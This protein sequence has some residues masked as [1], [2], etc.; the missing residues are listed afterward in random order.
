MAT[1][2]R[3]RPMSLPE[4][5]DQSIR[6]YRRHFL[7][8][9]G[10]IAIVQIPLALLSLM[11]SLATM[12]GAA[13]RF[14]DP[15]ALQAE[16]PFGLLGAGYWLGTLGNLLL[17][18]VSYVLVQGI[19]TGALSRAVADHYL[20][21]S[22][23]F[24]QA[25]VNVGGLWKRLVIALLIA[26]ITVIGLLIWTIIPCVGWLSGIGILLF[27]SLVISP[28]IA[29]IVVLEK[30]H[31]R[32]AIRRA[33]D[34]GRRRFWPVAGFVALL[35]LLNQVIIAGPTTLFGFLVEFLAGDTLMSGDLS[36]ATMMQTAVQSLISLAGSLIYLPLQL[37]GMIL[38]YFDL[39]IRTEGFDLALLAQS[40]GSTLSAADLVAQAPPP[41]N[42]R[43]LTSKEAGYFVLLTVGALVVFAV[44]WA[45]LAALLAGAMALSGAGPGF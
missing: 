25:Y 43:L 34:L 45:A 37:T 6:L 33:W 21:E 19:A 32:D 26:F 12:R 3:L 8:F 24:V 4:L 11:L 23:D 14:Q 5:L 16:N 30:Q 27:W 17:S 22:I 9:V 28:L 29:P 10:I 39:R 20:G 44:A 31:P 13:T 42:T 7:Q 41:E 35:F 36:A 15:Y 2:L 40:P 1:A 38:L 18:I